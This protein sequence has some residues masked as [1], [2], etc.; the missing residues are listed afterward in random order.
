M[1]SLP[2]QLLSLGIA[3]IL[4]S[5]AIT[6]GE[7]WPA[8]RG[9][10]GDSISSETNL[11]TSWSADKSIA[12]K[13]P[14]EGWG[15]STPA[16]I[17]ESIFVTTNT[18][19]GELQ[20]LKINKQN[21]NLIWKRT[22]TA[23]E[24][25]REAP[26]RKTQKFHRLHNLASPSPTVHGEI[27]VVHFG[28]GLLAAYNFAGDSLW[29]HDFQ[30]E[31]GAYSIWWGHA[32]SPVI[33]GGELVISI[34]MQDSLD[35]LQDKPVQSYLVA[36]DL[37]TGKLRWKSERMTGAHSEEGDAYTTPVLF[38]ANGQEQLIVMGGNQLDAYDPKTGK[39]LWYLPGLVGGR[40]ITG[41]T[42]GGGKILCTRG[43]RGPMIAIEAKDY[44]G[45]LGDDAI[46]WEVPSGTSDSPCSVISSGMAFIVTDDG[47]AQ[48]FDLKT[49]KQHW[50][51]R[52][53]GKYKAS[54]VVADGNIYFLSLDGT[55]TVVKVSAEFKQVAQNKL[56]DDTIASPA[57]SDGRIYLRGKEFLWA[58]E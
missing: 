26:K 50:K 53:G 20:L 51:E 56:P 52:I 10:N 15:S 2:R 44:S 25:P 9:P 13:T 47:I 30:K 17:G 57:I 54:P 48:C 32:N 19:T 23:A 37:K 55:C 12:W 29:D 43:M 45:E 11:P 3:L 7:D 4:A 31:Y 16:I 14:I 22:V 35:D 18:D 24:T 39:Q 28:N 41:P 1:I 40:T 42:I 34:C 58:I 46:Q 38:S 21:G 27:V 6:L 36:H 8:W 49:G 5:P 33:I